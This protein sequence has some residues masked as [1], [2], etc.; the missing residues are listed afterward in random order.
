[1]VVWL[2]QKA[3]PMSRP[4]AEVR[5]RITALR[6]G[7]SKR[8]WQPYRLL[9]GGRP[10]RLPPQGGNCGLLL[11]LT[12]GRRAGGWRQGGAEVAGRT[13]GLDLLAEAHRVER[14]AAC[15]LGITGPEMN[16]GQHHDDEEV[17]AGGSVYRG[18]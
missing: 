10:C 16:G 1:M 3:G 11:E 17:V 7:G 4:P 18:M 2:S 9:P 15:L 8:D 6:S 14:K 12:D 5:M 13:S